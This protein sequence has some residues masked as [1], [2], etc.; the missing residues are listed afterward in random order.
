MF[1]NNDKH[2]TIEDSQEHDPR[3]FFS[4][5]NKNFNIYFAFHLISSLLAREMVTKTARLT[6]RSLG[7][8]DR[9]LSR[10]VEDL[11]DLTSKLSGCN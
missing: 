10:A 5:N 9:C 8:A 6:F 1:T 4:E 2:K 3:K 11:S 7:V